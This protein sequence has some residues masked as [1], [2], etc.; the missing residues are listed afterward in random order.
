[1]HVVMTEMS[2]HRGR[3]SSCHVPVSCQ[4]H[5][6]MT[7]CQS[8]PG[9][10]FFLSC[11]CGLLSACCDDGDINTHRSRDSSCHVPVACQV[12]LVM[13]GMAILTWLENILVMFLWVIKCMF[14]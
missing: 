12:N 4:V 11:S 6:V 2:S 13:T 8:S 10:R 9:S 14:G 5:V 3:T 1:M 7:G